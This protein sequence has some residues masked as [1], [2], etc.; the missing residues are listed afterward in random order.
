MGSILRKSSNNHVTLDYNLNVSDLND[1]LTTINSRWKLRMLSQIA[2]GENQFTQ[3]KAVFPT[4]T[5]H[6]LTKRL[7]ELEEEKFIIRVV[8][9]KDNLLTENYVLTTKSMDLLSVIKQLQQWR[10]NWQNKAILDW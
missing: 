5:N 2:I 10:T 7:L 4:A 6:I 8:N 3:L 1:V 9:N